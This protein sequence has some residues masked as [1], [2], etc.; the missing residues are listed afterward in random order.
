MDTSKLWTLW[1]DEKI[2]EAEAKLLRTRAEDLPVPY[3]KEGRQA[4]ET[5]VRAFLKRDDAV[6]LAAPQIGIS[7]RIIVFRSRN[8][9]TKEPLQDGDYEVLVNPRITQK[10]GDVETMREGCLSCPDINVEVP[11]F[12][13]IKV[14]ACDR[15]GE[16]INIR[17]TGYLARVVQHEIDHLDGTLILDRGSTIF[18]PREKEK[19]FD[20]IFSDTT[21]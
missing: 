21:E 12:I 13:E 8:L 1:A 11:R 15:A 4:I 17:Y 7:K 14:K 20:S 3:D 10:R 6:G 5:V 16:K 19:F 18:Y 2:N 9:E